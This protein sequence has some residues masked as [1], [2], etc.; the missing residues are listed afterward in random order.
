MPIVEVDISEGIAEVLLLNARETGLSVD[1]QAR[2]AVRAHVIHLT[3][4]R[5]L[6]LMAILALADVDVED[7]DVIRRLI[8]VFDPSLAS[9][10]S[11]HPSAQPERRST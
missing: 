2:L 3:T 10:H 1:E 8:E 9:G 7:W 4:T 11:R 6:G 5:E